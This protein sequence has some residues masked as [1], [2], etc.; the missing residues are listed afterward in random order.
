MQP[1]LNI[2]PP[3]LTFDREEN[4]API[5][6]EKILTGRLLVSATSGGGKSHLLRWFVEQLCKRIPIML[7]DREGEYGTLTEVHEFVRAGKAT[8]ESEVD[9][10]VTADNAA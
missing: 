8:D 6:L 1:G 9:V 2:P 5:D 10:E 4:K 7:V 3:L